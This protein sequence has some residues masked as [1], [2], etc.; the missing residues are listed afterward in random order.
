[1]VYWPPPESLTMRVSKIPPGRGSAV[2]PA[3]GV[4]VPAAPQKCARCSG[5]VMQRKTSS[6]GAS[7]TRV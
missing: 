1:M 5:S 7:K 2:I 6:R 3:T 4:C